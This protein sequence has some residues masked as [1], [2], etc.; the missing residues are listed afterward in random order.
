MQTLDADSHVLEQA[1]FSELQLDAP[2]KM[3]KL[4]QMMANTE[5]Y[6]V[7]KTEATK[8]TALNEGWA[9]RKP[10][11]GFDPVSCFRRPAS[12]ID[13]N[14]TVQWIFSDGLASVSLFV[15]P[16][17]RQRHGQEAMVAMG[18]THALMRRLNEKGDWWLTVVGEVPP[19]TLKTFAQSLERR[20]PAPR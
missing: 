13:S 2:V 18:A 12:A 1:A 16:Y 5:G 10:V 17:D 14:P 3:E 9:L 4:S 7:E 11:A 6:R 8:T 20:E 19:A 15:E